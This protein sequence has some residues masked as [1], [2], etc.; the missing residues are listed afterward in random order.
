MALEERLRE[1][2]GKVSTLE[3]AMELLSQLPEKVTELRISVAGLQTK[4]AIG[5]TIITIVMPI[6]TALVLH[7]LGLNGAV[8][9][10][11]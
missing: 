1:L 4:L 6:L 8:V 11:P 2:E 3:A 9:D 5:G 10:K 7:F